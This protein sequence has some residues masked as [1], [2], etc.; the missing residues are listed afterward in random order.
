MAQMQENLL[1]DMIH[2]TGQ[3][4]A[5]IIAFAHDEEQQ[6]LISRDQIPEKYSN[7]IPE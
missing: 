2:L 7:L 3:E 1:G 5:D 6:E 4:L